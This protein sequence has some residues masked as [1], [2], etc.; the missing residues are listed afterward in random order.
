MKFYPSQRSFNV[1][2]HEIS[3]FL[4]LRKVGIWKIRKYDQLLLS[5]T[6]AENWAHPTY[7][8]Y[9]IELCSNSL[10]SHKFANYLT[11]S[12]PARMC[13]NTAAF[14][15]EWKQRYLHRYLFQARANI[16]TQGE[17]NPGTL[18]RLVHLFIDQSFLV[19]PKTRWTGEIWSGKT[20][21]LHM[22]RD[23]YTCLAVNKENLEQYLW[24]ALWSSK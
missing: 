4:S 6:L 24:F 18:C 9:L 22:Q 19:W 12:K 23:R 11:R 15:F 8:L 14:M 3:L 2:G 1:S 17:T 16:L 21:P 20:S 10:T 13:E 5:A 7:M